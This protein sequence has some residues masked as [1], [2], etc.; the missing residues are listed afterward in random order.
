MEWENGDMSLCIKLG[1]E[2]VRYGCDFKNKKSFW[3]ISLHKDVNKR[4]MKITV[5]NELVLEIRRTK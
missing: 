1:Q 5:S 3:R 4:L 2:E